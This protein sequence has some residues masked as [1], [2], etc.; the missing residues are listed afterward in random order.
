[1]VTG[2]T[3]ACA[4][5]TWCRCWCERLW[6]NYLRV[7]GEYILLNCGKLN[8]QELPPRARRI[9]NVHRRTS[10]TNEL[11]PRARRIRTFH[12]FYL[13]KHGTTSACAE[14]TAVGKLFAQGHG[15]YLR[16]RGE[17][18]DA[19]I[20]ALSALELPPRA[21]RIPTRWRSCVQKTRNYLRVRGEY[22]ISLRVEGA[23]RELPPRARRIPPEK[24]KTAGKTGTTSACAENTC[25]R[26]HQG[27][28]SRNYLRVRGEYY[29]SLVV[30]VRIAE[31]PPRARRI[32]E[33]P[34]LATLDRGTT[35][36]CAENT[37]I[38]SDDARTIKEL[39][40]RARRIPSG[41]ASLISP[42]GT[43]SACAEN[44]S[45]S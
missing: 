36:A 11:P 41:W 17:Y 20:G 39:P 43:T 32:W 24:D 26:N 13:H 40:P 23:T 7:R 22:G 14:N 38:T 18:E 10:Q 27:P 28:V 16:V 4:E 19:G 5:N 45:R 25:G 21:R 15:N 12:R 30:C 37:A 3:S 44:T 8:Q 1:M 42:P 2:T 6:W 34:H 31:L 9:Q 33:I 35:S 29:S